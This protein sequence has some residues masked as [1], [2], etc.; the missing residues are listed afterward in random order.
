MYTC[1]AEIYEQ[2][3][4]SLRG[5]SSKNSTAD[6][7]KRRLRACTQEWQ[8]QEVV[9]AYLQTIQ[10]YALPCKDFNKSHTCPR[11]DSSWLSP[12]YKLRLN[13]L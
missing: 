10:R 3:V 2:T 6:A 9:V 4:I 13:N 11:R 12:T 8:P 1:Q 7:I 5:L